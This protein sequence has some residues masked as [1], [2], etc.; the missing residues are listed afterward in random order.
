MAAVMQNIKIAKGMKF[1][2]TGYW[3]RKAKDRVFTIAGPT[4]E[5]AI[6]G[7]TKGRSFDY[8]SPYTGDHEDTLRDPTNRVLVKPDYDDAE[9]WSAFVPAERLPDTGPKD[10]RVGEV[11]AFNGGR[12]HGVFLVER[13]D[14]SGVTEARRLD[15]RDVGG[16]CPSAGSPNAR[17]SALIFTADEPAPVAE[18]KQPEPLTSAE[19]LALPQTV[20]LLGE[21]DARITLIRKAIRRRLDTI[22]KTVVPGAA[23][24]EVGL[25]D[26]DKAALREWEGV[27]DLIG[28]IGR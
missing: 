6:T 7:L 9:G 8:E 23:R 15:A 26:R 12:D 24:S 28:A 17:H 21:I 1:R 11:Y 5:P 20:R 16:W 13:I 22:E 4:K 3:D 18:P 2:D 14:K 25:L 27:R 10:F 19:W